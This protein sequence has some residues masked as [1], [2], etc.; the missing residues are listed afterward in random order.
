MDHTSFEDR[1]EAW[2]MDDL[3]PKSAAEVARHVAHCPSCQAEVAAH[4]SAFES[5][6]QLIEADERGHAELRASFAERLAADRQAAG[7][8]PAHA[9][10]RRIPPWVGWA[11]A[12]VVALGGFGWG[13]TV[14][15]RL[16]QIRTLMAVVETG[17]Q[18]PLRAPRGKVDL[19]VKGTHAVVW[20]HQLPPLKPGTTYQGW[21]IQRGHPVSAGTFGPGL[22]RLIPPRHPTAFAITVEP[23]GGTKLPTSP[24]IGE[25]TLS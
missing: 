10:R 6:T 5:L 8:S 11:A 19:Y 14:H 22:A 21:W 4:R 15:Q 13:W 1:L 12:L 2:I 25:T 20:V 16:D 24:V 9:I 17:R 3:D 7:R 23:R 18:L